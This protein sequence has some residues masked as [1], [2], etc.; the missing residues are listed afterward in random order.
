MIGARRQG[1]S[2]AIEV[3]DSG[4]GIPFAEVERVF[5][6]FYQVGNAER[7]GRTALVWGSPPSAG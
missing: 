5:E 2:V 6:E 7:D 1:R 4:S 3:W